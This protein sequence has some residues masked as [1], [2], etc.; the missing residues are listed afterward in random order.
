[1]ATAS[2]RQYN[3]RSSKQDILHLPVQLQWLDDSKCLADLL[4]KDSTTNKQVTDSDSSI[5]EAD[6]KVLIAPSD[7]ELPAS[8]V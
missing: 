1:M 4:K 7:T 5:D 6:C 2:N 8:P 3:F